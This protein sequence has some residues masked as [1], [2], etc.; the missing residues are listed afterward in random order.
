MLTIGLGGALALQPAVA[1]MAPEPS[2]SG[3]VKFQLGIATFTLRYFDLATT[4][5]MSRRVGLN[6]VCF[7]PRHLPLDSS[8]EAL[9]EAAEAC[10]RLGMTLYGSG[11]VGSMN[12]TAEVENVFRYATAAGMNT[13]VCTPHPDMFDLINRK[14]DETGIYIAIHNHLSGHARYRTPSSTYELIKHLGP[15]MGLCIDVGHAVRAGSDAVADIHRY[16]DR[17]FDFHMKDESAADPSGQP[18]VCGRGVLDLPAIVKALID[19]GYDRV[20]AF[21][22]E[23]N[24]RD[25]MPGLAESVGYI[26]GLIRM[27]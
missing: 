17:L 9:A 10:R 15:H 2:Q 16:K 3:N 20:V 27:M 21:E 8:D 25:P 23:G 4:L 11:V 5:Q 19:T 6:S 7:N 22:Y 14:A 26:R 18:I 13:I 24:G 1:A 12:N